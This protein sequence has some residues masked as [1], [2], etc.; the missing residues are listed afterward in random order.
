MNPTASSCVF[1]V[2]RLFK[3]S[4][5][6]GLHLRPAAILTKAASAFDADVV[7]QYGASKISGKSL[8]S[9]LNRKVDLLRGDI[10]PVTDGDDAESFSI[11]CLPFRQLASLLKEPALTV[12][13]QEGHEWYMIPVAGR[14][15][16]FLGGIDCALRA[17]TLSGTPSEASP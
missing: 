13:A 2:H 7:I 8:L 14:Y 4:D 3:V 17:I 15:E 1:R 6:C 10:V 16:L 5:P 12:I 9:L 11:H